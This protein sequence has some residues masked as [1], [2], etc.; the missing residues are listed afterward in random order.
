MAAGDD[1]RAPAEARFALARFLVGSG[2]GYEAI[3]VLNSIVAQA[4]SMVGEPE[5]RGLRGAARALIGRMEEAQGDFAS[6]AV[7]ADPASAV[8]RGYIASTQGDWESAR[9]AFDAGATAVDGFPAEWRARFGAA[10]AMAA[11]ELGDLDG[12][13]ALLAYSFSQNAPAADQLTARL[14]QARL[15]ELVGQPERALAV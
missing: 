11:L 4:P 7:A 5:L 13:R 12:A 10:H 15:F 8:W 3:G 1:P 2:L 6:A 9:Q 14:I